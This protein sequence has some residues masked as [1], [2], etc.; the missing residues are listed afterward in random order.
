MST[1]V[2]YAHGGCIPKRQHARVHGTCA[3]REKLRV[4]WA[5]HPVLLAESSAVSKDCREKV[6]E[7]M[8]EGCGAP[9]IFLAKSAVLSSFA[10]GR[11]TSLVLDIG[12][13]GTIGAVVLQ[14]ATS[15]P[16]LSASL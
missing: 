2:F 12:Y 5:D 10:L 14:A 13:H 7:R 16:A 8:F 3:C 1:L 9:A 6:T 15:S 4:N 11:Q